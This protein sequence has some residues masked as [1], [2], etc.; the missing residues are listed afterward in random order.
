[1]DGEK[2]VLAFLIG[3]HGI[4][5]ASF[6]RPLDE[7]KSD[8]KKIR[9]RTEHRSTTVGWRAFGEEKKVRS[10]KKCMGVKSLAKI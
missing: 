8:G 9:D 7:E 2:C 5:E 3:A 6:G 4:L 10:S 1:M